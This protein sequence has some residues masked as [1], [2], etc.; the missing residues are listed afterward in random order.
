MNEA[1]RRPP[2]GCRAAGP[3]RGRVVIVTGASSGIG[4]ATAHELAR[5][6]AHRRAGRAPRGCAGRAGAGDHGWLVARRSPSQPMDRRGEITQFGRAHTRA[7]GRWTCWSTTLASAQWAGMPRRRQRAFASSW[8]SICLGDAAVARGSAG[9]ART[10]R[11]AIIAVS[12][13][14]GHVASIRSTPAPSMGC[15][16]FVSRS[17][18]NCEAQVSASRHLAWLHSHLAQPPQRRL[19]PGPMSSRRPSPG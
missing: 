6:G 9:H 10:K 7:F 14:A 12:S 16:D 19:M 18:G 2:H 5:Q 8:M 1:T 4:A 13:V 15:G 3:L 11:G 17:G